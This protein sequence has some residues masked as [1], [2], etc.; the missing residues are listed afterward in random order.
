[1]TAGNL[2]HKRASSRITSSSQP[3]APCPPRSL[4]TTSPNVGTCRGAFGKLRK[5][6]ISLVG[7]SVSVC[8]SFCLSVETHGTTRLPLD[9]FPG[10]LIF[11]YFSKIYRNSSLIKIGQEWRVLYMK[12]ATICD[13]K[14]LTV[15]HWLTVTTF[16]L[17]WEMFQ[18]KVV[19][20]IKIHISC[21]ITIFRKPCRIWDSV[22]NFCK[23]GQVTDNNVYSVY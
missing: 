4:P 14:W 9:G 23:A 19:Q 18:K 3:T 21:P 6:T 20:K 5:V 11:K 8:L 1:M 22:E 16:C 7:V 17:E 12:T 2:S 13:D 15:T 10:K